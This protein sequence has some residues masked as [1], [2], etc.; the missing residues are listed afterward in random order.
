MRLQLP[1]T[2]LVPFIGFCLFC[3]LPP[4]ATLLLGSPQEPHPI[5]TVGPAHADVIGS[6][7]AAIQRAIDRVAAAGGGTVVIK[8]G[9]YRL[10]NSI[11]LSSHITLRGEGPGKTILKKAPGIRTKLKLDADYGEFIA[12]VDDAAQ[13]KP[14]MGVV[15]V[16]TQ[17]RQGWTPSLRTITNID[18]NTLRFDR[19][20]HIDYSVANAGE[21]FNTF[22]LIAGYEVEDVHVEDL[23]ADGARES[24][25]ILDGCQ[26]GAIYFFHSR[27]MTIR[28]CL[29]RNYPGDGISCQFVE[30]PV[31]D[32]C[33]AYGN[34]SLGIHL[35]TGA[36]RGLVRSNRAHD[37]GQDGLY[38][39]WRVQ[40]SRWEENQSWNNGRDGISLGHKDTDNVFVT[41]VISGNAHAG[42]YFRDE[43][44]INAAHRNAF[45]ENTISD[46]G[47]PGA[48]GYGI[49]IDGRT[50]NLTFTSNTIRNTGR[51]RTL[52]QQVGIYIGPEADYVICGGNLFEGESMQAVTDQSAGGH[53]KLQVA[54]ASHGVTGAKGGN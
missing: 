21:V 18:G 31:V 53:N 4:A 52:H 43:S 25:E 17:Q 54:P 2:T 44:E 47:R 7:N 23:T 40:G 33:E 35:G 41:N 45:V 11:R 12:T 26:A 19:F 28:N 20:L 6:D 30:D 24:S 32:N 16:D 15:V 1:V 13:L 27:K 51:D 3:F 14:G 42:V 34:A 22:P 10:E 38:L 39:C 48:P 36:L 9:T 49:R 5:V 29:A 46:N 37:N 8:A 50:K